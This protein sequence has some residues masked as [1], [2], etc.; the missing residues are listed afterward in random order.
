MN[1]RENPGVT[2]LA[3]A[4]PNPTP[5]STKKPKKVGVIPKDKRRRKQM[6]RKQVKHHEIGGYSDESMDTQDESSARRYN[7]ER[8]IRD[9][10]SQ[11]SQSGQQY[12]SETMNRSKLL[13]SSRSISNSDDIDAISNPYVAPKKVGTLRGRKKLSGTGTSATRAV[14]KT[15]RSVALMA[16]SLAKR[17][18][19]ELDD[20][21]VDPKTVTKIANEIKKLS[22]EY[23]LTG[24]AASK[25]KLDRARKR[26]DQLSTLVDKDIK[27]LKECQDILENP[28]TSESTM[29]ISNPRHKSGRKASTRK[30][31]SARKTT[32]AKRTKRSAKK[33]AHKKSSL[34]QRILT[35]AKKRTTKSR[36][37]KVAASHAVKKRVSTRKRASRKN[38]EE[39]ESAIGNPSTKRHSVKRRKTSSSV[40]KAHGL[41][42]LV[43]SAL[44]DHSAD[45]VTII[46]NGKAHKLKANKNSSEF[47]KARVSGLTGKFTAL[48]GKKNHPHSLNVR[49]VSALVKG[50]KASI[51]DIQAALNAWAGAVAGGHVKKGRK[52]PAKKVSVSSARRRKSVVRRRSSSK[53]RSASSKKRSASSKRR[54]RKASAVVGAVHAKRRRRSSAS[55]VSAKKR[56]THSRKRRASTSKKRHHRKNPAELE[57]LNLARINDG[58]EEV[59]MGAKIGYG[60]LAFTTGLFASNLLSGV[61][62]A[63]VNPSSSGGKLGVDVAAHAVVL[64]VGAL[65]YHASDK[66]E[67]AKAAIV[68]L[69]LGVVGAALARNVSSIEKGIGKIPGFGKL[70]Q[71]SAEAGRFGASTTTT[72]TTTAPATTTTPAATT[73]ATTTPATTTPATTDASATTPAADGSQKGWGRLPSRRG[74][75]G[76]GLFIKQNPADMLEDLS[77][78]GVNRSRAIPSS[79]IRKS[80][81]GVGSSVVGVGSS[82]VGVGRYGKSGSSLGLYVNDP[83]TTVAKGTSGLAGGRNLSIKPLSSRTSQMQTRRNPLGVTYEVSAR[84]GVSQ[85]VLQDAGLA[86]FVPDNNDRVGSFTDRAERAGSYLGDGGRVLSTSTIQAPAQRVDATGVSIDALQSELRN[87]DPLSTEELLAEGVPNVASADVAVIRATPYYARTIASAQLGYVLKA[88]DR[89]PGSYLVGLYVAPDNVMYNTGIGVPDL[90]V[91]VGART[92]PAGLFTSSIFSSV[93]PAIDGNPV[94][95]GGDDG[96]F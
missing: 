18:L 84:H 78:F 33:S 67:K 70:M 29:A 23:N 32:G 94:W 57:L 28:S 85:Q 90:N 17:G 92:R 34:A 96:D 52:N 86:S 82:V 35:A 79:M 5:K 38:P 6:L 7:L 3:I 14:G 43:A 74:V 75:R 12:S 73:P 66:S 89:V 22:K 54:S 24:S 80:A 1:I 4:L 15:K 95:A 25:K 59:G 71:I 58:S 16:P 77:G 63:L 56:A 76:M 91:P 42:R 62:Q 51:K 81:H 27:R 65:G 55:K 61:G 49:C 11:M 21:A 47:K 20:G 93:L 50:G 40:K 46:R 68:G 13:S 48:C 19:K 53:K 83:A 10:Q 41:T 30:A 87:I 31:S 39:E 37:S 8:A 88:S 60:A 44:K 64:T 69:G 2:M 72:T 36:K 26:L 9:V 45:S